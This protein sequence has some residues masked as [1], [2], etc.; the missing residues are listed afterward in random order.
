MW[1]NYA[2]L[3]LFHSINEQIP[4]FIGGQVRRRLTLKTGNAKEQAQSLKKSLQRRTEQ[5]CIVSGAEERAQ[6]PQ[7]SGE[8]TFAILF[9][10]I[11]QKY[12]TLV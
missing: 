2:I 7:F 9:Q 4:S 10:Q 8:P 1:L 5:V 3:S 12:L 11:S 6:V